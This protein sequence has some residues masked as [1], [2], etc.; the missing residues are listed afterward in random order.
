MQKDFSWQLIHDVSSL[1]C[2]LLLSITDNAFIVKNLQDNTILQI[3]PIE[4]FISEYCKYLGEILAS[5]KSKL[6]CSF[7]DE[8]VFY[9][10]LTS[11]KISQICESNCLLF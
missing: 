2:G 9:D 7:E 8:T 10:S 1:S 4:D 3:L 6:S 5:I 11:E